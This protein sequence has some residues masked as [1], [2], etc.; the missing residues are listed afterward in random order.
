MIAR[1][2]AALGLLCVAL[3]TGLLV[4]STRHAASQPSVRFPAEQPVPVSARVAL[5]EQRIHRLEQRLAAVER[6]APA[7]APVAAAPVGGAKLPP[8]CEPPYQID[9]AG[10]KRFKHECLSVAPDCDPP[11]MVDVSGIKRYK[12][13]CLR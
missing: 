13:E 2:S 7:A 8:D 11:Y 5:L 12:P 6:A 1:K 10:I 3:S 4:L 9:A